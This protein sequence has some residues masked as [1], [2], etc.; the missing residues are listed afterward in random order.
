MV[1]AT[2]LPWTPLLLIAL[3]SLDVSEGELLLVVSA[4]CVVVNTFLLWGIC[5]SSRRDI[6]KKAI[7]LLL[8]AFIACVG[9][10]F[11]KSPTS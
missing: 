10:F 1:L 4:L 2:D 11:L 8:G 3:E 7:L 5:F 9:A 6:F